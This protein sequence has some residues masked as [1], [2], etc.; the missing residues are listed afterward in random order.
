MLSKILYP[1]SWLAPIPIIY[2]IDYSDALFAILYYS[3]GVVVEG[4]IFAYCMSFGISGHPYGC[5]DNLWQCF[6][7]QV[8]AMGLA[9]LSQ[10]T[11]CV[12][13][14]AANEPLGRPLPSLVAFGAIIMGVAFTFCAWSQLC[15]GHNHSDD[16]ELRP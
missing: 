13:S 5:H 14:L 8:I 1:L 11:G 2:G 4:F 10:A 3:C 16:A 9:L 6:R 15:K 12:Y 7:V